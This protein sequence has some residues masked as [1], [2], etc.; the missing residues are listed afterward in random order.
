MAALEN[1]KSERKVLL[2]KLEKELKTLQDY[3]LEDV[4]AY[5]ELLKRN[6]IESFMYAMDTIGEAYEV[7]ETQTKL[8]MVK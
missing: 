8:R 5:I 4:E 7:R 3:E 1:R 6:S 2:K